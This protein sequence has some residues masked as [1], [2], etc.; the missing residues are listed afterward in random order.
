MNTSTEA[1]RDHILT[2][3]ANYK[4]DGACAVCGSAMKVR[5]TH[6][7]SYCSQSCF[8]KRGLVSKLKGLSHSRNDLDA[9]RKSNKFGNTVRTGPFYD[10]NDVRKTRE[11]KEG[12]I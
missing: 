11:K 8:L 5:D 10:Y 2:S 4:S 3:K 9:M 7:H 1:H 6:R 12:E